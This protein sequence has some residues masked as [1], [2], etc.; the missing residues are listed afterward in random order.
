MVQSL[1]KT[2]TYTY[3]YGL[4]VSIYSQDTK[5]RIFQFK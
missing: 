5:L 2:I 1:L 3:D 4:T